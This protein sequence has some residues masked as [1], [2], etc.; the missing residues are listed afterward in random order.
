VR[1]PVTVRLRRDEPGTPRAGTPHAGAPGAGARLPLT[2]GFFRDVRDGMAEYW[3]LRR[4]APDRT[5]ETRSERTMSGDG[6]RGL[7]EP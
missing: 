7:R 2:S 3:D 5:L 1:L 6:Q 4:A